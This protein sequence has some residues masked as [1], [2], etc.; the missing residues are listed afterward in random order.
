[1]SKHRFCST[2]NSFDVV[3]VK[4]YNDIYIQKPIIIQKNIGKSD[5]VYRWVDKKS[6]KSYTGSSVNL[7]I[8]FR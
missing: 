8:R 6:G 3:P 7:A 2:I 4:I 5:C 1:M